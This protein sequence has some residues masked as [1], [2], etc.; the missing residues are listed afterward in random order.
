MA[1]SRAKVRTGNEDQ[2][3]RKTITN[4]PWLAQGDIPDFRA[5]CWTNNLDTWARGNVE[6]VDRHLKD[7]DR[8]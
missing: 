1:I 3:I 8:R 5:K 6:Q 4:L 2:Q 7:D